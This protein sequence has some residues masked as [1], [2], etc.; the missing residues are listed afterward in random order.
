MIGIEGEVYPI[1]RKTF[2]KSYHTLDTP[3][4]AVTE[5]VP[6]V[7]DRLT[8]EKRALMPFAR[9]CVPKSSK[10][11]RAAALERPTKVFT[12]WDQERYYSGGPGDYLMANEG[13]FEDC[14]IIKERIFALSY[15]E[16]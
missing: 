9:T 10:L 4:S 8:G 7:T 3:Y 2:E 13:A 14:Y 1:L 6:T 5:Y 12:E 16:A 11:V 15:E